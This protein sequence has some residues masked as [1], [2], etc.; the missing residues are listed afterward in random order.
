MTT[1]SFTTLKNRFN[2]KERLKMILFG[3]KKRYCIFVFS[4]L[5]V[6]GFFGY[7]VYNDILGDINNITYDYVKTLKTA[8]DKVVVD[9]IKQNIQQREKNRGHYNHQLSR[10]LFEFANTDKIEDVDLVNN[11]GLQ[12]EDNAKEL[13]ASG[14]RAE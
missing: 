12:S 11:E 5:I 10:N 1:F 13:R 8:K 4:W 2:K 14:W 3:Y 7:F 9:N 6:V